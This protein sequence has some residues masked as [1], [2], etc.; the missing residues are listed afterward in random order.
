MS[1][2]ALPRIVPAERSAKISLRVVQTGCIF[3][4]ALVVISP[5]F[6]LLIASLKDDRFQILADMG[7]F[8]HSGL[9]IRRC[10]ISPRSRTSPVNLPTAAISSIRLLSLR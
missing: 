7:S 8:A 3:V 4:V 2:F 5:L 9:P 1:D 10:R 6:M